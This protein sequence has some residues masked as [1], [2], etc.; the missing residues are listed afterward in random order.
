MAIA[1]EL[2][3]QWFGDLVTMKWWDD[4]WLNE[5]FATYMAYKAIDN[6]HPEWSIWENFFNGEPRVETLAGAMERDS[7]RNTHPI[8]VQ[9]N[10]P[11][12]IE[13]IFDAISY[14]KGAHVLQMI[15]AYVGK[16]AFREGV[17]RY[18][19]AH[20]YSNAT[21]HDL[22]SAIEEASGK[23]VRKIMSAWIR[24]P[25]FPVVTA[26][27]DG[28]KLKLMQ[29]RLLLTGKPEKETWPTPLVVEVNGE[30]RSV[31][32][33]NSAV[34]IEVDRLQS[35]R[36]NPDRTGFYAVNGANVADIIWRSNPSSYDRWGFIFDAF[37]FLL[38]GRIG[39]NEFLSVLEN[40]EHEDGTLP[41]QEISDQLE[42][43]YT[44]APAK[45]VELSKRF[46]RALL[47]TFRDKPDEK[48]S[49]LRGT[50]ASR[51]AEIDPEYA[52]D[53]AGGFKEY[54]KVPPDMR[55]AVAT[56]YAKST[57]DHDGLLRAYRASR[58]EEDKI[59][60]LNS[61]TLFS[62]ER[63]VEGTLNFSLSGEVKRQDIIGVVH[64]AAANPYVRDMVWGWF[65][66]KIGKLQDLYH[67]TGLLSI[68]LPSMIPL[69]CVGRVA[70]AESFFAEH[71]IPDAETGIRVGLEKLHAYDRLAGEI[72]HHT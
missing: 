17:R 52:T 53:L 71:M 59:K 19:T 15:D 43:L 34:G 20:A 54:G 6:A 33:E 70:E 66:S 60:F 32:M 23:P 30:R 40:F 12:E 21:G 57:N 14:G 56:A 46:H 42:R 47:E 62:N 2:A 4:I 25:G 8:Q 49:I 58:S 35:L 13:Q 65:K 10:S 55:L 28:G 31:L 38:S 39:F 61:M 44:L 51:L 18:L 50:L 16:E 5:S 63:L 72:L 68:H 69:L 64:R 3:H 26:Q 48:S 22:W 36:I 41:A 27:L 24:Q 37:L 1:H 45:I 11:D 7:L 29:D 67:D 9:V